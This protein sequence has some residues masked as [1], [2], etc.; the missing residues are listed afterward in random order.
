MNSLK[1]WD[2]IAFEF[3]GAIFM[4]ELKLELVLRH[5]IVVQLHLFRGAL[6]VKEKR[7][8]WFIGK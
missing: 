8:Q 5:S 7:V 6:V 2:K 1:K 4:K 3:T